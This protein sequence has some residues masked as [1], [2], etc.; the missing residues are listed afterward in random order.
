MGGAAT[1]FE[2]LVTARACQGAFAALLS[3]SCL[4]LLATTFTDPKERAKAFGVFS[5]VVASGSGGA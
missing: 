3:P 4:A 5:G 1:N 2:M